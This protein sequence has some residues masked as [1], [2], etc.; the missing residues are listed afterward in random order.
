MASIGEEIRLRFPRI[1][2]S[3]VMAIIFWIL[4]IFVP[5]T[6]RG[7]EVPGLNVEAEL[8]LWVI[9]MGTTAIFLL[10]ALSDSV[11]LI[12]MTAEIVVRRFGIKGENPLKRAGREVVYIIIIILITTAISPVAARLGGPWICTVITYLA[13]AFILIFIYDIGRVLYGIMEQKAELIANRLAKMSEK[14]GE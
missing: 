8:F 1:T 10:R 12:D 3:L 4:S 11:V 14:K 7:I 5:P 2:M 9:L 13:L 6:F